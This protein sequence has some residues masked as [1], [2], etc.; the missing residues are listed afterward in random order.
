ML[1]DIQKHSRKLEEMLVYFKNTPNIEFEIRFQNVDAK[2][3]YKLYGHLKKLTKEETSKTCDFINSNG[4][5][6]TKTDGMNGFTTMIKTRIDTYDIPEFKIRS[7]LAQEIIG[8]D[9]SEISTEKIKLTRN[10]N[11]SSFK[12][13]HFKVDLTKTSGTDNNENFEVELEFYKSA[14]FKDVVDMIYFILKIRQDNFI[15]AC[16]GEN[17]WALNFYKSLVKKNTFIG[18]QPETLHGTNLPELYKKKYAVTK[19]I[20]GDR[21]LLMITTNMR[22]YGINSNVTQA[23]ST[24]FKSEFYVNTLIDCERVISGDIVTFHCFDIIFYNGIDLRG[25]PE[26]TLVERLEMLKNIVKTINDTDLYKIKCK[27][28]LFSNV[29]IGSKIMWEGTDNETLDGLIY[30]PIESF[31]SKSTKWTGLYKWKPAHLNTID[32]FSKKISDTEWELYVTIPSPIKKTTKTA[33]TMGAQDS[34]IILF[35]IEAITG[36][37]SIVETFKTNFPNELL[38]PTTGIPFVSDTVIEFRYNYDKKLFIPLK[39]RWDKTENPSKHGNFVTVALDIWSNILN[40]VTIESISKLVVYNNQVTFFKNMRFIHNRIKEDLYKTYIPP[41]PSDRRKKGATLLELCCGKGGDKNKW[42]DTD[43]SVVHGYDACQKSIIECVKRVKEESNKLKYKYKFTKMDLSTI[44][45]Q[46]EIKK[47]FPNKFDVASCQFAI[48]YFFESKTTLDNFIDILDLNL[49]EGGMFFIT[50]MEA[51]SIYKLLGENK[52]KSFIEDD[53]VVY[54]IETPESTET[55]SFG[56]K[57]KVY[58]N[59]ENVLSQGSDEYI[60][61]HK[62]LVEYMEDR[63]YSLVDSKMFSEMDIYP[64]RITV[65]QIS[66]YTQLKQYE[67]DIFNLNRFSAFKK[68]SNTLL[69]KLLN[70]I[71][72]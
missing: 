71:K 35:D 46:H 43:V 52:S 25:D 29:F 60:V 67:L 39:T 55:G 19:K 41:R 27:E 1:I 28:Y 13:S 2:F 42:T 53:Q 57:L 16:E 21:C 36:T 70:E 8:D 56:N 68:T 7:S 33:K 69:P 58:F 51:D 37:A 44:E 6:F 40:P 15:I 22:I 4:K 14:G 17:E 48:H 10:K 66:K 30:V 72:I 38:D 12:Y 49:K 26:S 34:N 3:F 50:Y 45:A 23:F 65:N 62:F 5:R 20:D 54:C 63:G 47:N 31:Y 9:V 61:D 59:G 32:F 18:A 24:D 11:R 64:P